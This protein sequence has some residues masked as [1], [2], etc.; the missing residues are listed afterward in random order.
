MSDPFA[1]LSGSYDNPE[2]DGE[3]VGFH[4]EIRG[5]YA[6]ARAAAK[7]RTVEQPTRIRSRCNGVQ[8]VWIVVTTSWAIR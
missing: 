2:S 4:V 1:K 6:I 8:I 5:R 3:D 7:G